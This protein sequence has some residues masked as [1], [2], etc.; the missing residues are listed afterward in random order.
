M[1]RLPPILLAAVLALAAS[2][3][4][5][6][7]GGG[8]EPAA[9]EP[10]LAQQGDA[11]ASDPAGPEP[12][13]ADQDQLRQVMVEAR[14]ATGRPR[15]GLSLWARD[16]GA[17][18]SHWMA[19][20]MEQNL[21][22]FARLWAPFFEPAV[23]LL[24]A[25]LAAVVLAFLARLALDR[26]RRRA[27]AETAPAARDPGAAGAPAAARDWEAELRRRLERRDAAGA[28][29]A[30]WWWLAERL[31][32]ERAEPSWTSRELIYRAGRR[33][34]LSGVRRLDRM[35]YGTGRTQ[36][37]DVGRLWNDL[38]AAVE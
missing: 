33:D 37:G 12:L 30:L 18:F 14:V 15:P 1:L 38:K 17:A 4:A 7:Q 32:G 34:L 21:P 16:A 8:A 5:D 11:A 10:L 20:W 36:T 19:G 2:P 6:G 26:W 28:I 35:M 13:I 22:R 24:L 23:M 31:V 27:P 25:L 3:P 9:P 29:E